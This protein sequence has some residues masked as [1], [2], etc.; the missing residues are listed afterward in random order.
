MI[1]FGAESNKLPSRIPNPEKLD[2]LN[3]KKNWIVSAAVLKKVLDKDA[4]LAGFRTRE[5]KEGK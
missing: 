2:Q 5:K 1:R 4:H 3:D